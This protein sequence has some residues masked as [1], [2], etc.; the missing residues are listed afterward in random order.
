VRNLIVHQGGIVDEIFQ[1]ESG[2][3]DTEIGSRLRVNSELFRRS[4]AALRVAADA[5]RVALGEKFFDNW[6]SRLPRY[7]SVF[8]REKK[9]DES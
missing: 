1:R 7:H 9:P 4:T 8:P 2:V 5:F 3:T 6:E